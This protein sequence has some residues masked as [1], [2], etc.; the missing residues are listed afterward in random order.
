MEGSNSPESLALTL[1]FNLRANFYFMFLALISGV[2][3]WLTLGPRLSLADKPRM[4]LAYPQMITFRASL[5]VSL[6]R[7]SIFLSY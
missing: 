2:D 3:L 6:L 7:L 1:C 4:S 5:I